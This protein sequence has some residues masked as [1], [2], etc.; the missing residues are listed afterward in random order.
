MR[1]QTSSIMAGAALALVSCLSGPRLGAASEPPTLQPGRENL[2]HLIFIVMR[3]QGIDAVEGPEWWGPQME[4]AIAGAVAT[5]ADDADGAEATAGAVDGW[6]VATPRMEA[7]VWEGVTFTNFRVEA[8]NVATRSGLLT[9]RTALATGAFGVADREHA[10]PD[11][12]CDR[13]DPDE[14]RQGPPQAARPSGPSGVRPNVQVATVPEMLQAAGYHTVYIGPGEHQDDHQHHV[15][16]ATEAAGHQR[17]PQVA[18]GPHA[19]GF[20]V[21]IDWRHLLCDPPTR[22]ADQVMVRAAHAAVMAVQDRP[23]P[24]RPYALFFF[25]PLPGRM[26]PQDQVIAREDRTSAREEEDLRPDATLPAPLLW[27]PIEDQSLIPVTRSLPT[28]VPHRADANQVRTINRNRFLQAVEAQDEVLARELLGPRGLGVVHDRGWGSQYQP[29]SNTTVFMFSDGGTDPEVTPWPDGGAG[30]LHEGGISTPLLVFGEGIT[31]WM[32]FQGRVD[33]RLVDE[34]DFRATVADIIG[35]SSAQR[36]EMDGGSIDRGSMSF[37]EAINR[38]WNAATPV[39]DASPIE[40][41][42]PPRHRRGSVSSQA[43][44]PVVERTR[45]AVAGECDASSPWRIAYVEQVEPGDDPEGLPARWKLICDAASLDG[46]HG[47]SAHAFYRLG[48]RGT[49]PTDLLSDEL[50]GAQAG[51][52]TKD[53]ANTFYAMR[54]RVIDHWPTA[55]SATG[56]SPNVKYA[57]EHHAPPYRLVTYIVGGDIY[58]GDNSV[59]FY[60][61]GV[62]INLCEGKQL[63]TCEPVEGQAEY[64]MLVA[65]M[66]ANY[67]SGA[68]RP[69]VTTIDI[70]LSATLVLRSDSTADPGPLTVGHANVVGATSLEYRALLEFDTTQAVFPTGFSWGDV[71]DAQL[72]VAFKEDSTPWIGDRPNDYLDSEDTDTGVIRVHPVT[73]PWTTGSFNAFDGGVDFGAFDPP[74]HIINAPLT[75]TQGNSPEQIRVLPMPTGTPVSFGHRTALTERVLDWVTGIEPN[76]GVMLVADLLG[77]PVSDPLGIVNGDQQIKFLRTSNAA[78]IRLTLDRR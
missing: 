13:D 78:V 74:P 69:D 62:P 15:H 16:H 35:L 6:I 63:R 9:G 71:V 17:L 27:W 1:T 22:F 57:V 54:D 32:R 65:Q 67:V 47:V 73:E 51:A 12:P 45:D 21:V 34:I 39:E 76:H 31:G 66:D 70:P 59:Q 29:A 49:V 42:H 52:M 7:F 77:G 41:P 5:R 55:V 2:P 23:D 40:D 30:T 25:S 68:L 56:A 33:D 43:L 37:A 19:R 4:G 18:P 58:L 53:A 36:L 60:R 24:R 28:E 46:F 38:G 11:G 75:S 44:G 50:P 3:D 61:D 20:D 10:W 26:W 48:D 14:A 72:I 8:S 64:Y